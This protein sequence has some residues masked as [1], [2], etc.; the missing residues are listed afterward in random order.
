MSESVARRAATRSGEALADVTVVTAAYADARWHLTC[1]AIE[2][3]LAQRPAPR[4]IIV[5]V[6]HN[7]GLLRKLQERW[8]RPGDARSP[9]IRVV[10]M[11]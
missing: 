3:A 8:E 5:P 7:P 6:D 4:E 9:A 2:S 10:P 11:R 1:R